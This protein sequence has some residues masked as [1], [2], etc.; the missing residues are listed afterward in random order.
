M[1]GPYKVAGDQLD[2]VYINMVCIYINI[3]IWYVFI[4]IWY[5]TCPISP[6]MSHW[7]VIMFE[8]WMFLNNI[9]DLLHIM[10]MVIIPLPLVV[11]SLNVKRRIHW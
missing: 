3:M 8:K 10:V 1:S 11:G 7:S 2:L 5:V 6:F 9:N 4:S